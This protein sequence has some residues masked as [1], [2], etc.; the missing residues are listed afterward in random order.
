MRGKQTS[1][2]VA[3]GLGAM[4][5]ACT[6]FQPIGEHATGWLAAGYRCHGAAVAL[7]G[8]M[9]LAYLGRKEFMPY[10]AVAVGKQW[11]ALSRPEQAMFLASMRIIGSAWLALSVA[12]G[13]MLR[14]G[15]R[16]GEAWAVYGVPAVGLLVAAPTLAAVLFVKARTPASPPWPP[17][18]VAVILFLS[19]LLLSL[20]AGPNA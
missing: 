15:F 13:L 14:H 9:G 10:H 5:L 12:L 4:A 17:L 8:L 2:A 18:A 1:F 3:L 7:F 19:G 16:A 11:S 6:A 20:A